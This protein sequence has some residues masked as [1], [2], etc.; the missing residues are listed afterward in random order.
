M[1]LCSRASVT[2]STSPEPGRPVREV[3]EPG[4]SVCSRQDRVDGY[5]GP[6][7]RIRTTLEAVVRG[8]EQSNGAIGAAMVVG[9][10]D[11]RRYRYDTSRRTALLENLE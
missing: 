4:R 1:N 2:Q 5:A 3:A 9:L 11:R 10:Q 6:R 8:G 7:S